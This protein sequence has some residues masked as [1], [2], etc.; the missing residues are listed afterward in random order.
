M[1]A[2]GSR[3]AGRNRATRR[4]ARMPS[5]SNRALPSFARAPRVWKFIATAGPP[6]PAPVS[7]STCGWPWRPRPQCF[8]RRALMA[9]RKRVE[10]SVARPLCLR[11]CPDL[12]RSHR[13]SRTGDLSPHDMEDPRCP[14]LAPGAAELLIKPAS[15]EPP[16]MGTIRSSFRAPRKSEMESRHPLAQ[17][18]DVP[19]GPCL[20]SRL[21]APLEHHGPRTR[22][23][24]SSLP[25]SLEGGPGT[26]RAFIM[27]VAGR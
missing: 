4:T 3:S 7:S 14:Q 19:A 11:G 16:A 13:P 6:R 21:A 5:S 27:R 23:Q 15:E 12:E 1:E 9:T 25:P 26:S 8:P 24:D 20:I 10:R 18:L 22:E 17:G 2:L